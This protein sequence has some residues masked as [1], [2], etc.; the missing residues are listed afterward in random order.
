MFYRTDLVSLMHEFHW[1]SQLNI[2]NFASSVNLYP[3]THEIYF[4]D[5]M[6]RNNFCIF[7]RRMTVCLY[8]SSSDNHNIYFISRCRRKVSCEIL[9]LMKELHALCLFTEKSAMNDWFK[10]YQ[11]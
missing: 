10:C 6:L 7:Y 11:M 9:S 2:Y 5:C 4:Y 3:I 8:Q 1:I